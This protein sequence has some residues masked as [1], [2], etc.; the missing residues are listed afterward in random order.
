MAY[1]RRDFAGAAGATTLAIPIDDAVDTFTV[2]SASGWPTGGSGSFFAVLI[3]GATVEKILVTTRAG[4]TFYGVTRGAEGTSAASF[5]VG[6]TVRHITSKT[7]WDEINY[8]VAELAAAA[9]AANDLI[10][11]DG[12]NSLSR[13]A[14]GSN[15]TA[16]TV[17]SGGTLGYSTI[18][19]AMVDSVAGLSVSKLESVSNQRFLGNITGGSAVPAAL[20]VAQMQAALEIEAY[21]WTVVRK[22]SDQ[23]KS[24]DVL[25]DYDDDLTF[26]AA[27]GTPYQF[28]LSIV[29]T[30]TDGLN[31]QIQVG[32]SAATS[33][34]HTFYRD[35]GTNVLTHTAG[36]G[37]T[38]VGSRSLSNGMAMIVQGWHVGAGGTFGL[39]WA[40]GNSGASP[41]TVKA[42]SLL[43]YRALS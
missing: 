29:F 30:S 17:N 31:I 9:T 22:S 19:N 5:P 8:W 7:D 4:T 21:P 32:E 6:A 12:D 16:L 34:W 43:S 37:A 41:T 23:A 36:S 39:Q 38:N 15:S 2:T 40:Q 20:T 24:L 3:S 14:K 25:V 13:I 27:S 42:G 10:I 26:T 33:C 18:T 1:E 11:A 35:Q 28:V